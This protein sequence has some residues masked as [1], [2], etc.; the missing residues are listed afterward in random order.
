MAGDSIVN[1]ITGQNQQNSSMCADNVRKLS[2]ATGARVYVDSTHAGLQG[3]PNSL[4]SN[5]GTSQSCHKIEH[6]EAE[7][8]GEGLYQATG[9]LNISLFERRGLT[10]G[11]GVGGGSE[12]KYT[13]PYE[14]DIGR[15]IPMCFQARECETCCY[16][17]PHCITVEILGRVPEVLSPAAQPTCPTTTFKSDLKPLDLLPNRQ[18]FSSDCPHLYVCWTERDELTPQTEP[19][20][21]L[22]TAAFYS[23]PPLVQKYLFSAEDADEGET[24]DVNLLW[25][26]EASSISLIDETLVSFS[27]YTLHPGSS[28]NQQATPGRVQH[29]YKLDRTCREGWINLEVELTY[30]RDWKSRLSNAQGRTPLYTLNGPQING[31]VD[32][33]YHVEFDEDKTLCFTT[34]D[35]QAAKWGR[36]LNNS[37]IRCHVMRFRGPPAFVRHHQRPLDSPFLKFD[38]NLM[39]YGVQTIEA[40]VGEEISLTVRARDPNPEDIVTIFPNEDPGLPIGSTLDRGVC[41]EHGMVSDK[42]GVE[43]SQV[44]SGCSENIRVFRWRPVA[45]TEGKLYRVCFVARDNQPFC[46]VSNPPVPASTPLSPPRATELGFYSAPYCAQINVTEARVR[47]LQGTEATQEGANRILNVGCKSSYAVRATGGQYPVTIYPTPSRA[48]ERV[49]DARFPVTDIKIETVSNA[50]NI[51]DALVV[52]EPQRGSEG[53][54]TRVCV[55]AAP[56]G[57]AGAR[58]TSYI[59]EYG[60]PAVVGGRPYSEERCFVFK[61]MSWSA[62]PPCL[63][64]VLPVFVIGFGRSC[65]AGAKV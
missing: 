11:V 2:I 18:Q 54:I 56:K 30:S 63:A 12:G 46:R 53:S 37:A 44:F 60:D 47:W 65:G 7:G 42:T 27:P 10:G 40:F 25:T 33:Y 49:E 59:T 26:A 3:C 58:S 61:V 8:A 45:G 50:D 1:P 31:P 38:A 52:W 6:L 5:D 15:K 19:G 57:W 20:P 28:C 34:T 9:V 36:G 24:V 35:N 64:M 4:I 43:G 39:G 14:F 62:F 21:P 23:H 48:G 13:R 32:G 22:E 51:H 55:V 41:V 17:I 16:S 29:L